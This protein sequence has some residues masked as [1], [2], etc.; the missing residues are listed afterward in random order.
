VPDTDELTLSH[1]DIEDAISEMAALSGLPY[2]DLLGAARELAG[3]ERDVD[4]LAYGV[5]A[6]AAELEDRGVSLAAEPESTEAYLSV[7]QAERDKAHE[8]GNSLPDKSYP[9]SNV[10]QLR[11]AAILAASHHGNWQAARRLI[12]RRAK[13]LG[14]DLSTL[15]GFGGSDGDSDED[16][17][18]DVAASYS[19]GIYDPG[20]VAEYVARHPGRAYPALTSP[21]AEGGTVALTD[22]VGDG[23]RWDETSPVDRYLLQLATD[24]PAASK[25]FGLAR[26]DNFPSE[27]SPAGT[28]DVADIIARH[29]DLFTKSTAGIEPHGPHDGRGHTAACPP[30]CTVDH[31]QP[32]RGGVVHPEVA[33]LL[34]VWAS[35]MGNR[36]RPVDQST[37]HRPLSPAERERA[38]RAARPGHTGYR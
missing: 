20:M 26:E 23:Y 27:P 25:M 11:S 1:S 3:G 5:A 14:V 35:K 9:I 7:S 21:V 18:G 32:K 36:E 37:S 33:R 28:G 31:N 4:S 34:D 8:A 17:D 19:G 12:A 38:R 10:K 15:P 22:V 24:S 6:L 16:N 13:E 29:Q 2:A 30:D